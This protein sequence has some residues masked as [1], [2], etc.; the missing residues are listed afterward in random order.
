M[1]REAGGVLL[2]GGVALA[3]AGVAALALAA[4][5]TA[6]TNLIANGTFEGSGGGSL[7]GWGASNGMLAIVAG[8]GGGQAAR[9]RPASA[10]Q[11]YAYTTT[12]PHRRRGDARLGRPHRGRTARG[13][14]L[15][16]QA[17]TTARRRRT[18]TRPAATS[19]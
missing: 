17:H 16:L 11:V 18:S 8:S 12:K 13:Q 10:A 7:T 9:V 14:L 5:A 15:H 19:A 2:R 4:S 1:R 6:A 3:V